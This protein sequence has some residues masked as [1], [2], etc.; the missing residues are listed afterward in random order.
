MQLGTPAVTRTVAESSFDLHEG[1]VSE[2]TIFIDQA[3]N[4]TLT[5]MLLKEA[6]LAERMFSLKIY[7]VR[8]RTDG[9]E[10]LCKLTDADARKLVVQQAGLNQ[11]GVFIRYTRRADSSAKDQ[12]L[13]VVWLQETTSLKEA[14]QRG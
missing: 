14:L 2:R 11:F 10:A 9:V 3:A 4:D 1:G 7:S 12:D 8:P 5:P 6:G 13:P